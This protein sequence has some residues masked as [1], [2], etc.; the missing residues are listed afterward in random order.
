MGEESNSDTLTRHMAWYGI[1]YGA[2]IAWG[3][4]FFA[5][6]IAAFIEE[7]SVLPSLFIGDQHAT[8]L[9]NMLSYWLYLLLV[10]G[11]F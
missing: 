4:A 8:A 9:I 11:G 3:A 10:V 1:M 2:V 5:S 6:G 7:Y